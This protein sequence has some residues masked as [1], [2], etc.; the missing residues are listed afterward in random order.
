MLVQ[1]GELNFARGSMVIMDVKWCD[2]GA[3]T[4]F[5]GIVDHTPL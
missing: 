3:D 2:Y 4:L 1:A 5:I